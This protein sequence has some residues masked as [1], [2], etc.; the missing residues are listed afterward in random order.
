LTETH[1]KLN[2]VE[3]R[4][5]DLESRLAESVT[6]ADAEAKSRELTDR[7]RELESRLSESVPRTELDAAKAQAE[8][9]IRELQGKLS[10]SR[11][12]ADALKEKVAGLDSRVAEAER[13]LE[14]ARRRIKELE[15]AAAKPPAEEKP[16]EPT[17]G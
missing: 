14:T 13:Q 16:P 17:A 3:A 7:I 4:S 15:A 11:S 5:R 6:K 9:T 12:E 8:S 2:S 1:E 10:E